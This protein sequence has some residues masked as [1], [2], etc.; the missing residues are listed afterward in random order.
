MP[1][2]VWV[3]YLQNGQWQLDELTHRDNELILDRVGF[4]LNGG[5]IV[6]ILGSGEYYSWDI[7]GP[8]EYRRTG[9]GLQPFDQN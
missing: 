5:A 4:L 7:E 9:N 8:I 6:Q 1:Y 2:Y 3:M